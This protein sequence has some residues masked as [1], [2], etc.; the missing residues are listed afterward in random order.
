MRG[1]GRA[2]Q[3]AQSLAHSRLRRSCTAVGGANEGKMVRRV[4]RC[5][6]AVGDTL[7]GARL[8]PLLALGLLI[9]RGSE[10]PGGSQILPFGCGA[11]Q[12]LLL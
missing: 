4:A 11:G 6:P 3:R 12:F 1:A 8:A 5:V 7:T 2:V 9:I 10:E